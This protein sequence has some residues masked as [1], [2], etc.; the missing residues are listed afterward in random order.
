MLNDIKKYVLGYKQCQITKTDQQIKQN[1]LHPNEVPQHLWDI[2]SLDL[3]GPLPISKEYDRV[4]V[5]VDRFPKITC[6]ILVTM[7]ITSKRVGKNIWEQVFKD[8]GLP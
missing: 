4:L 8:I 5:V 2:I 6:Y 3:V 1:L 7:N